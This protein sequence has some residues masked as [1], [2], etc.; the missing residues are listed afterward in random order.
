[1]ELIDLTFLSS[2]ALLLLRIIVGAV[3]FS[4]GKSHA[5]NPEKRGESIGMPA[6]AAMVLG[7]VEMLAAVSIIL[8]IFTQ[9]GAILIMM[10]ML[11]A[12]YKKIFEWK[13]GFYAE[14]GF[15]WHYDLLFFVAAFVI[16][17]T[18]GGMYTIY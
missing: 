7:I 10:V 1:M 6:S 3:F 13:T 14:K 18:N 9:V 15:G 11:G 2:T 5:T 12:I 17:T 16:L 4:S 8:G